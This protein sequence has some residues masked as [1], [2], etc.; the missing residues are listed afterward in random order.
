V[1]FQCG[2]ALWSC[3]VYLTQ[4][5]LPPPVHRQAWY[6]LGFGGELGTVPWS[7]LANASIGTAVDLEVPFTLTFDEQ[8][9]YMAVG[10][11]A[12]RYPLA[13]VAHP[14]ELSLKENWGS[15]A[16]TT[17]DM[18][19]GGYSHSRA[20]GTVATAFA[21]A[22]AGPH[23]TLTASGLAGG[24]ST[25]AFT[26]LELNGVA[27]P[28]GARLHT[29][30]GADDIWGPYEIGYAG[31][32]LVRKWNTDH[33][34]AQVVDAVSMLA[35]TGGAYRVVEDLDGYHT[36]IWK[37]SW[38]TY[39][40]NTYAPFYT[41]PQLFL[42]FYGPWAAG[43]SEAN[44]DLFGVV[45]HPL[46]NWSNRTQLI[47]LDVIAWSH[48]PSIEVEFPDGSG[49]RKSNW[50]ATGGSVGVSCTNGADLTTI[51]VAP[52]GSGGA[53]RT[54]V[55]DYPDI[56]IAE[57][58]AG[59]HKQ[60][61]QD[62]LHD[63]CNW[64]NYGFLK[65][66]AVLSWTAA[67]DRAF[68][69]EIVNTVYAADLSTTEETWTWDVLALEADNG[70]PTDYRVDLMNPLERVEPCLLHVKTVRFTGVVAGDGIVFDSMELQRYNPT[71]GDE[72]A[73]DDSPAIGVRV[74]W[75]ITRDDVL[76]LVGRVSGGRC[77]QRTTPNVLQDGQETGIPHFDSNTDELALAEI[78]VWLNEQEG[79]EAVVEDAVA[80]SPGPFDDGDGNTTTPYAFYLRQTHTSEDAT[81]KGKL[82]AILK[83][84]QLEP[85]QCIPYVVHWDLGMVVRGALEGIAHYPE[86]AGQAWER[87]GPGE[88]VEVLAAG[89]QT[90]VAIAKTD[91]WGRYIATE[92][93]E[94]DAYD[95]RDPVTP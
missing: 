1:L 69:L 33:R 86:I 25:V 55:D 17:A 10:G 2:P 61:R 56:L 12:L 72:R 58:M 81:T 79:F 43:N 95:L 16:D 70:L 71:T 50:A 44:A 31:P 65:L 84:K 35:P 59:F 29:V 38:A 64:S 48:K 14:D 37:T 75:A 62:A 4:E 51:A 91:D 45:E 40:A 52:G 46:R 53:E 57:G 92:L 36:Q 11:E 83:A 89:T 7:F 23:A 21:N 80:D 85:A 68:R 54:L 20:A 19:F 76:C 13:G 90:V 41:N 77:F 47:P 49:S 24:G 28:D 73:D 5:A 39:P 42:R 60:R 32:I 82:Q 15:D 26:D 78:A 87:A 63:I 6:V 88:K 8:D 66:P 93:F 30:N 18:V 74:P 3:Q 27:V 67:G 94:E 34:K 22:W 9:L